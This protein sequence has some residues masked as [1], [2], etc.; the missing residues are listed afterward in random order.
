MLERMAR[1]RRPDGRRK[2]RTR[3]NAIYRGIQAAG[4]PT[5][6]ARAVGVS[7]PTL[8]RWR[9]AGRVTDAA[10]VLEWAALVHPGDAAAAYQLARRLAGLAPTKR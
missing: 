1:R 2:P 8:K 6:L 10:T 5:Q 4:G 9:A 3:V 7:V